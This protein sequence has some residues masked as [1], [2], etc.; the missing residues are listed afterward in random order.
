MI[1][2]AINNNAVVDSEINLADREIRIASIIRFEISKF[3]LNHK[4][5]DLMTDSTVELG[6][7]Y[8]T[9]HNMGL[10]GHIEGKI[11]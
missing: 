4:V 9:P 3:V 5:R 10:V 8:R 11:K 1:S 7:A 6:S 2:L